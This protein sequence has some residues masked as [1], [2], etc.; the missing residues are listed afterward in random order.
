MESMAD[1]IIQSL[2]HN[3]LALGNFSLGMLFWGIVV[4][5]YLEFMP[6]L[7]KKNKMTSFSHSEKDGKCYLHY[8]NYLANC[9]NSD[10]PLEFF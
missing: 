1:F 5:L 10:T 8:T 3:L 4:F 2:V 9:W 6:W 7:K